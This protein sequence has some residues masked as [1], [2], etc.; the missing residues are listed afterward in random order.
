MAPI[1]AIVG[2]L[3]GAVDRQRGAL[4]PWAPVAFGAGIACYFALGTE[5]P[6]W[7]LGAFAVSALI[8]CGW[9]WWRAPRAL[10]P[11]LGLALFALGLAD[12]GLRARHVATPVLEGRYYGPIEGRVVGIDR[13]RSDRPRLTLD[14]VWLGDVPIGKVPARVRISLHGLVPQLPAPGARVMTTGHL[15]AP[16]GAVEPGGFDFRRHA[17]FQRIGAVGYTRNPLLLVEPA[18]PQAGGA[19]WLARLRFRLGDAVRAV[20]PGEP[21]AFAAAIMTGDRSGIR[22]QT[23]EALRDSNLAHLLAISGLHMGLLSGFVFAALRLAMAAVPWLALNWPIKKIAAGGALVAASVYYALS[24]GNVATE[25]AFVMVAVALG[26][27]L[28]DRRALTLRAVAVAALIVLAVRPETLTS[29][30]FQ[31]SFAATAALVGVF[32]ALRDWERWAPRRWARGVLAVVIS[33]AVAG[34]A[35]APV[36]AAHFNRISDYGL[37]ANLLS[38]PLMGLVVIPGAVLAALLAPLGLGWLGLELMRPAIVWILA[39]AERVAA[40]PGAVTPVPAPPAWVLPVMAAGGLVALIWRG[41]G[42]WAGLPLAAAAVAGWALAERPALLVSADG[43]LLGLMTEHGRALSKPRGQGFVAT[44]WLE[45]DGDGA[46]QAEAALRPAFTREGNILRFTLGGRRLA[47]LSGRGARERLSEACAGADL[48][49]LAAVAETLPEGCTVIDRASL[50]RSGALAIMPRRG[51]LE[52]VTAAE[53]A[54]RRL[55]HGAP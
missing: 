25:R 28:L 21:G 11:A 8:L 53:R 32:A 42:R 44:I 37:V 34:L 52:I 47:Q 43:A 36:A 50:A 9:L 12:A 39:V 22:Q 10:A 51:S 49:I 5:P 20:L 45:N 7:R 17:W 31:M 18:A 29:P 24:G 16:G 14:E 1:A 54:G 6:L 26:A 3:L 19:L 2:F 23:L 13:S 40:L 35:T 48:V 4:M 15:A 55:W 38:V 27:V 46:S 30:G 33:S 41:R